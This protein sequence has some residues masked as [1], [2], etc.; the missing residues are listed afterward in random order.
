MAKLLEPQIVEYEW[1]TT[2]PFASTLGGKVNYDVLPCEVEFSVKFMRG[3][4]ALEFERRVRAELESLGGGDSAA[5]AS[6]GF[7]SANQE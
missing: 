6:V 5:I 3:K 4:D 2:R 7:R 1:R